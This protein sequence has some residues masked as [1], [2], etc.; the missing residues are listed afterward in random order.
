MANDSASRAVT[1]LLLH[2]EIAFQICSLHSDYPRAGFQLRKKSGARRRRLQ[3]RYRFPAY[4]ARTLVRNL[5]TSVLSRVLSFDSICAAD[6]TCEEAVPV[7]VAPRCTSV[8]LE[9]TC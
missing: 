7:S 6:S 4:A 1:S 3:N 8:M 9:D 5:L 2:S